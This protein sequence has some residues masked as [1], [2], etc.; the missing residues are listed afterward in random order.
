MTTNY[1]VRYAAKISR[2]GSENK[3]RRKLNSIDSKPE[4]LILVVHGV[5][6]PSPGETLSQ[7]ARSLADSDQPLN[8]KQ[9]VIWLAE[10]SQESANVQTFPAHQRSLEYNHQKLKLCEVFWG[11]LSRV[12]RGWFGVFQGL[13]QILFG[14]RYVAY[15]AADQPGRAAFGLKSLGLI[16]SR[17]LHGPVLAVTFYLAVLMIAVCGTQLLWPKSYTASTWTQVVLAACAMFAMGASSIGFRLTRSRVIERFWFWVNVTAMFVTGLMFL[18][19]LFLDNQYP[20]I[21]HECPLHPGLLF[22]CRVLLVLLGLLWFVEIQVLIG[23]AFCWL[24]A[25]RHPK[26]NRPA[27]HVA[28]LLPA[29]AIGIWGQALPM[30]WISAKSGIDMLAQLGVFATVFDD[31]IPFLGVQLMMMLVI[32]LT[33]SAVIVRYF[34]WRQ[35]NSLENFLQ[36]QRAPR[37]IVNGTLQLV[38]GMCTAGGVVAVYSLFVISWMQMEHDK[39]LLGRL[40]IDVNRYAVSM[41]VPLG[42]LMILLL[43]KL[44]PGFD[45]MLDVV[46]HFYFRATS[47]EDALEDDDEFN[48]SETTFENGALFFSRRDSLHARIKRILFHYREQYDHQPELVIIS[49][50][51]GTMVA[52]E[53]LN[54]EELSWLNDGFQSVSL[55]TMGSPL[56]HLYQHYFGHCYPALDQPFWSSLRRRLD[57]WINICRMDDFVGTE[58][59]FPVSHLKSTNEQVGWAEASQMQ[60]E[61]SSLVS[62]VAYS[63]FAVGPRGHV[64]YWSDRE[65][66]TILRE[67]L[68]K[69]AEQVRRKS[70]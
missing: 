19:A 36:G 28:F 11:D 32:G 68:F 66:L 65:V 53:A 13:F 62:P 23:M 49:H 52:I 7:F 9:D 70:A 15:V 59:E 69:Q 35:K 17:I 16:S 5:G 67:Q 50:S 29:M 20:E 44:R 25:L 58:L 24:V 12:R 38:I 60:A 61:R 51:Q 6:D 56:N 63:N 45:I 1:S 39:F 64:N 34:T 14:I 55:I 30:I 46:N 43:P 18:R 37:L 31:A 27:L 21:I 10:E 33:A 48:M 4:K 22:Y 2:S 3:P 47:A 42:S 26:A 40:M 41:I 54:D 8:E 57:R